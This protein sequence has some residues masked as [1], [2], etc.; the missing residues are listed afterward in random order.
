MRIFT[1]IKTVIVSLSQ[2]GEI[3]KLATEQ[4]R[5]NYR[6]RGNGREKTDR[7]KQANR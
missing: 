7:E 5:L 2:N 6:D 1:N 4:N 3:Q